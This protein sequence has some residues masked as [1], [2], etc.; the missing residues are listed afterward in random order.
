MFAPWRRG[1]EIPALLAVTSPLVVLALLP[2]V[3]VVV[4]QARI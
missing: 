3:P 4:L 2:V 1:R